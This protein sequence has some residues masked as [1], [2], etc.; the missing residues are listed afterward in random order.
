MAY[1]RLQFILLT[2]W[3]AACA[4]ER[5]LTLKYSVPEGSQEPDLI[6][7]I[8]SDPQLSG[9]EQNIGSIDNNGQFLNFFD[10]SES[11]KKCAVDEGFVSAENQS[12][13]L[14]GIGSDKGCQ[15]LASFYTNQIFSGGK[16]ELAD[17]LS[18]SKNLNMAAGFVFV[19]F[20]FNHENLESTQRCFQL[21]VAEVQNKEVV[22]V[23]EKGDAI[24]VSLQGVRGS[25]GLPSRCYPYGKK[26]AEI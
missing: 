23:S 1:R 14:S 17:G 19:L 4:S 12:L 15:S 10:D 25:E 11:L 16:L 20:F 5:N 7:V 9:F 26:G 13:F 3:G 24:Q 18:M 6:V 2:L 21:F 8:H 22:G